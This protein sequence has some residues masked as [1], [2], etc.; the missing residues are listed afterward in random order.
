M[1]SASAKYH[2]NLIIYAL[3]NKN[4]LEIG[5]IARKNVILYPQRIAGHFTLPY[6]HVM[7][8][9]CKLNQNIHH[10]V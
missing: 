1:G 9:H 5:V 10:T 6:L 4:V 2:A 3:R 7:Q 8:T